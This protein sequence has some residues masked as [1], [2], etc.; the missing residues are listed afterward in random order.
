MH[1]FTSQGQRITQV[2]M[3]HSPEDYTLRKRMMRR[4]MK[5]LIQERRG[6]K[7]SNPKA[8]VSVVRKLEMILYV[9]SRS[10]DE[11]CNASTLRHRMFGASIMHLQRT[12]S[13]PNE[14]QRPMLVLDP[15]TPHANEAFRLHPT[16]PAVLLS[17]ICSFLPGTTVLRMK[18]LNRAARED[19]H[20]H[21]ASLVLSCSQLDALL[22]QPPV[23]W[24]QLTSFKLENRVERK[25]FTYIASDE[26]RI[27]RL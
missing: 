7:M 5:Q 3:W 15:A 18:G 19:M 22:T 27:V 16:C 8:L 25:N 14:D 12:F 10:R 20:T 11:Y 13:N 1:Y 24:T 9:Q 23:R 4:I 2:T 6:R 17:R 26:M 21:V